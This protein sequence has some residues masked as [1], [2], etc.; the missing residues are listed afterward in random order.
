LLK[1][2]EGFAC[3]PQLKAV[4]QSLHHLNV[5]TF[6]SRT[7]EQYMVAKATFDDEKAFKVR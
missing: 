5:A 3:H 2:A 4:F 6:L 7:K 1:S